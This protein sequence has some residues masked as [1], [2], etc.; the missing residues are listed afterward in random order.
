MRKRMGGNGGLGSR[1]CGDRAVRWLATLSC[2]MSPAGCTP[3]VDVAGVYFPGWLVST[4]GGV[5]ASYGIVLWLG[6][7]PDTKALADSGLFFVSLVAGI[8]LVIWWVSFSG[9]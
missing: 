7:R 6:R 1:Q 5:G 9:F 2:L 4:I 3:T 8:A